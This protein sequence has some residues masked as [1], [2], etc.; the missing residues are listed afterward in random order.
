MQLDDQ[1]YMV[2][3]YHMSLLK[4]TVYLDH[5][6]YQRLKQVAARQGRTPAALVREAVSEYAAR[7]QEKRLPTSLGIGRSGRGDIGER[8]EEFLAGMGED[9]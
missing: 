9:S 6:D 4:T 7:H 8:A 5:E 2:Y 1:R 3:G